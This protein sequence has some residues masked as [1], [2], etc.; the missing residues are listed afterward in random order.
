MPAATPAA[1][2]HQQLGPLDS[3]Y[4]SVP[5][6]P[7]RSTRF[8]GVTEKV[9]LEDPETGLCTKLVKMAPGAELPDHEHQRIE[10]TFVL[11]GSLKD[12]QGKVTAGNYVWR[13]AGSRHKAWAPNGCLVIGVFLAPNRFHD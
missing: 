8:P 7:W 4:V 2:Q 9:L 3:R 10:Q 12:D 13:P 6:L 5:D 11:E 1:M